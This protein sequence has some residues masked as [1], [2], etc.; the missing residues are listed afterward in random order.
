MKSCILPKLRKPE[1][2]TAMP[3]LLDCCFNI[4]QT[5]PVYLN[6]QIGSGVN[7]HLLLCLLFREH[8]DEEIMVIML[9]GQCRRQEKKRSTNKSNPILYFIP[10]EEHQISSPD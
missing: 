7:K 4:Y 1:G 10:S 3:S 8:K 6:K 2:I 5:S 9:K